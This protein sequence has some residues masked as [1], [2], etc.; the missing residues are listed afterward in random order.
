M[1]TLAKSSLTIIINDMQ[2]KVNLGKYLKEKFYLE[3]YWQPSF[4]YLVK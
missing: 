2:V 1:L 3:P 4:K